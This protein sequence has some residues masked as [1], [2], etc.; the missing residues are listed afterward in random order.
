[1]ARNVEIKARVHDL[2]ATTRLALAIA[3][4]GPEHLLQE[5]TYFRVAKGRLKLREFSESNAE[6]IYYRRPDAPGPTE[7]RYDRV[8]ITEPRSLRGVLA[9][10]LGV[11]GVV[12]KARTVCWVG[13]TRIHLDRVED[14]G[15]FL[16]LEVVLETDEPTEASHKE[17]EELMGKLN[18]PSHSL[19][20]GSYIDLL[21]NIWK[22][23]SDCSE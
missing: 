3:D 9:E 21:T 15:D 4:R 8:E 1:M 13:R 22:R 7:S 20:S 6:L 18:I 17:A 12:K 14:L 10:A 11:V 19:L 16:E 23:H 5:D 2:E